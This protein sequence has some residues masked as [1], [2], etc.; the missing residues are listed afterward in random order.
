MAAGA[1]SHWQKVDATEIC[2]FHLGA[3]LLL[4]MAASETGPA[5]TQRLTGDLAHGRP[6]LIV[7]AHHWQAAE[8]T[9]DFTLVSCT[10]SPAFRF[11]GFTL[12]PRAFDIPRH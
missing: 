1:R 2:H 11:E 6:Q 5:E 8:T 7:P 9:G 4:H 12:A 10:V 3:D